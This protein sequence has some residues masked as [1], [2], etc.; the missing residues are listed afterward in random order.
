MGAHLYSPPTTDVFTSSRGYNVLLFEGVFTLTTFE[1]SDPVRY[2][3]SDR[4]GSSDL[5]MS[6]GLR[7]C[8]PVHLLVTYGDTVVFFFY[9]KHAV[10]W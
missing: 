9:T 10:F 1:F 2:S 7:R 5:M 4:L 6:C 8:P 3:A